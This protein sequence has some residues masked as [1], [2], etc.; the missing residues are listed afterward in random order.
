MAGIIGTYVRCV[1]CHTHPYDPFT[2]DEYYK[3]MA[4]YND[5]EDEDTEDDYPC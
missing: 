3:F 1:Q 2:H 4:F 5:T